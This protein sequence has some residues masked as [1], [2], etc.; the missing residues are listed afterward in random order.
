VKLAF[1]AKC[2]LVCDAVK[3]M[4]VKNTREYFF[5]STLGEKKFWQETM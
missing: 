4:E 3:D 1:S 2:K 5:A